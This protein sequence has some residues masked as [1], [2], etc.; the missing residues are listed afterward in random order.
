MSA[1]VTGLLGSFATLEGEVRREL[2]EEF[3]VVGDEYK[4]REVDR[5]AAAVNSERAADAR[6]IMLWHLPQI[7][8][9][10]GYGCVPA[11]LVS[12]TGGNIWWTEAGVRVL[13]VGQPPAAA[14]SAAGSGAKP[15][16]VK[17]RSYLVRVRHFRG[18]PA[19]GATRLAGT[20]GG[21]PVILVSSVDELDAVEE[22]E[23]PLPTA[24]SVAEPSISHLDRLEAASGVDIDGD[25]DVG[26]GDEGCP[27][28]TRNRVWDGAAWT[29]DW[30]YGSGGA[31]RHIDTDW[32]RVRVASADSP[33]VI[34]EVR[35]P[36]LLDTATNGRVGLVVMAA[37]AGAGWQPVHD[38]HHRIV[39]QVFVE[40][41]KRK[42][43]KPHVVIAPHPSPPVQTFKFKPD[44]RHGL[45]IRLSTG[46]LIVGYSAA[47]EG[48]AEVAGVPVGAL[49]TRVNGI[50]TASRDDITS[51][52]EEEQTKP[53]G[54]D[55]EFECQLLPCPVDA[56]TALPV[57]ELAASGPGSA[58]FSV[59]PGHYRAFDEELLALDK[60]LQLC[61]DKIDQVV[62][63]SPSGYA[64][65]AMGVICKAFHSTLM[66]HIS[67]L[68]GAGVG[69]GARTLD[70]T[71]LGRVLSWL[72]KYLE[73]M[74]RF[75]FSPPADFAEVLST[76]L[77]GRA[78]AEACDGLRAKLEVWLENALE[79]EAD[80]GTDEA[81]RTSM[82]DDCLKALA[83]AMEVLDQP[84]SVLW[85]LQSFRCIS[86]TLSDGMCS[87]LADRTLPGRTRSVLSLIQPQDPEVGL[88]VACLSHA[89]HLAKKF[90]AALSSDEPLYTET[91]AMQQLIESPQRQM[92]KILSGGG[93]AAHASAV[94][95]EAAG[96]SM[97]LHLKYLCRAVNNV[98]RLAEGFAEV[99]RARFG[100]LFADDGATGERAGFSLG[101]GSADNMR[102]QWGAAWS[103]DYELAVM[104]GERNGIVRKT[105]RSVRGSLLRE[106]GH[107]VLTAHAGAMTLLQ[108]VGEPRWHQDAMLERVVHEC[109]DPQL[110][111]VASWLERR[112]LNDVS[113][114]AMFSDQKQTALGWA[115][116]GGA[117]GVSSCLMNLRLE[118]RWWARF[119]RSSC[120]CTPRSSSI[121]SAG[122]I[123]SRIR[124]GWRPRSV[125]CKMP[126]CSPS[127]SRV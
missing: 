85:A 124:G 11:D 87:L 118:C 19:F 91:D 72:A 119:W 69:A 30:E 54:W 114:T 80:V 71:Q 3:A 77:L 52:L 97:M 31:D 113:A 108:S 49:I 32:V 42:K 38:A 13:R 89:R 68:W 126:S 123:P 2:T 125:S 17:L 81:L 75:G 98:Q 107:L 79:S 4:R 66:A 96:A 61:V 120:S 104:R 47:G 6:T 37:S 28:P 65:V 55:L 111:T 34:I 16:G 53:G 92:A 67:Q 82:P 5:V 112:E 84:K 8:G 46:G 127:G 100:P 41:K 63:S 21:A 27:R 70:P 83:F 60:L 44:T 35:D 62:L 76:G 74:A 93:G 40:V 15:R 23:P 57:P 121:T 115:G 9:L 106:I 105:Y 7:R 109:I 26:R 48:A 10:G 88:E 18:A 122:T 110:D 24:V 14:A 58:A 56:A 103:Y 43:R 33:S 78:A 39:G 29:T 12:A 94:Q 90:V 95:S 22:G 59:T 51:Q 73:Y 101:G 64:E 25:G 1:G 50:E 102:A 99:T 117:G 116:R 36:D 86:E 45:G 20:A